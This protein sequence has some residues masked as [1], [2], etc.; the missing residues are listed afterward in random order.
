MRKLIPLL[1]SIV[2]LLSSCELFK[3]EPEL[4]DVYVVSIGIDYS[5]EPN[6]PSS[7]VLRDL[8]GTITDAKE[9]FTTLKAIAQRTKRTWHGFLL[10]QE[11]G[12]H[13]TA[14]FDAF[15]PDTG[16]YASKTHL[17]NVLT[18]IKNQARPEDLVIITYSGHGIA[19]NGDMVMAHTTE[20]GPVDAQSLRVSPALLIDQ[21]LTPIKARK[22]LIL[23]SC[24]SGV[25]VPE[26]Q[27]SSSTVLDSGID[28]WYAKFWEQSTY[29][30]PD[31]FVLTASAHTDSY[32]DYVIGGHKHGV[33]T[34]A[35]LEALGWNHP[36]AADISTVTLLAPPALR[37]SALTVDSIYRYIINFIEEHPDYNPKWNILK[38]G[39]I[40]Q[41]PL[42]LGGAM[43][44]VLFRF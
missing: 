8:S 34:A 5:N 1:L 41:H 6:D 40:I 7:G 21:Y 39:E 23:D 26:S 29:G 12:A 2:L 30:L 20:S 22:L 43:D 10:L 3:E 4:G 42:V 27:S 9:M 19:E 33:F 36:H 14:T 31:L 16:I 24:V 44:M 37:N 17:F 11:G 13:T 28:D 15:N 38:L 35:L 25:F 32:E 18:T